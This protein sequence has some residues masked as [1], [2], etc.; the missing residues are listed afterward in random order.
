MFQLADATA[1]RRLLKQQY[2]G[3]APKAAVIRLLPQR[4]EDAARVIFLPLDRFA[5]QAIW[6][7]KIKAYG[8]THV[9]YCC[10]PSRE[11]RVPPAL[12]WTIT[13]LGPDRPTHL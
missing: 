2:F 13:W 4:I 5:V 3:R 12:S 7:E 6:S 1:E 8:S 10:V 9:I 11:Q